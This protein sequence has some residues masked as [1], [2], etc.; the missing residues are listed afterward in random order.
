M[1]S[2]QS[3]DS[4]YKLLIPLHYFEHDINY[5]LW[6]WNNWLSSAMWEEPII[7]IEK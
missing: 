2:M 4:D 3:S 1:T 7:A 6:K 5:Q